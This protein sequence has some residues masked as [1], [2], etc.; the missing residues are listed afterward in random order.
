MPCQEPGDPREVPKREVPKR[1]EVQHFGWFEAEGRADSW[2]LRLDGGGH[3]PG[4]EGILP[5]WALWAARAGTVSGQ[6]LR[7]CSRVG[8]GPR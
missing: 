5:G 6:G 8:H 1:E 7:A 4:R 2:S 3:W